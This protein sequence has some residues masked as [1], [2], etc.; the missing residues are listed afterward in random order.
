[1]KVLP[2]R[3]RAALMPSLVLALSLGLFQCAGFF[4]GAGETLVSDA[5][6]AR[7][8][9]Q[10]HH[11]LMNN[12]TA[13]KEYPL[14]TPKNQAEAEFQ[15]YVINLCRRAVASIP[16]KER[17]KYDFTF[18]L[19]DKDEENAFAVPGGYVYI[20][21]GIL[22]KFQDESELVGVIGHEITHV[23]H[24]HF[25][26]QLAKNQT[27]G[28][29]L[30]V[31]LGVSGAGQV[32]EMGAGLAFQLAGLSFSRADETDAD[33]GGTLML[34][35]MN[36]NPMGIAKYFARAESKGAPPEWLSTHPGAENRVKTIRK[37]VESEPQ[38]QQIA[39][40]SARTNNRDIFQSRVAPIHAG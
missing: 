29:A 22:R 5:D 34:A 2:I 23:T 26:E 9:A 20:Y 17:P 19:I 8:G 11:T 37:F 7:L 32:A 35:R 16:E 21:T 30:S 13:R 1:M 12:D 28:L 40:D 25:R 31:L 33:K 15:D 4:Q 3:A 24:H 27:L 14:F 10:F 38:L 39:A 36:L 6:E 18:T